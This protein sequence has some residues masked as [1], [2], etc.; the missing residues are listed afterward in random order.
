MELTAQPGIFYTID[1]YEP[2]M[3]PPV[4]LVNDPRPR[5]PHELRIISGQKITSIWSNPPKGGD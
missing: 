1:F 5:Y 2:M 4:W 3:L